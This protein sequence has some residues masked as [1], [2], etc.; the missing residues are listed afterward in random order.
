MSLMKRMNNFLI[1]TT[2]LFLFSE[3]LS[4]QFEHFTVNS[5]NYIFFQLEGL[6]ESINKGSQ[7]IAFGYNTT[8]DTLVIAILQDKEALV[9][10]Y[11]LNDYI[12]NATKMNDPEWRNDT[13]FVSSE[14][15]Y[16]ATTWNLQFVWNSKVES[17][18]AT[19]PEVYDPSTIALGKA[20]SAMAAGNIRLALDWY[21]SVFYPQNYMNEAEVG[22]DIT[23]KCHELALVFFKANQ[24]DSAILYMEMAFSY[25][26]NMYY[27]DF[28]SNAD[29][30]LQIEESPYQIIWT[31]DQIKLWLGDY[32]L[33]LYKAKKYKE[34]IE[35]N[36][37][38][39]S[40][41]PEMAGPYLQ[42]G[43]S[44]YDSGKKTEA[45]KA[46]TKYSSLKKAQKKEKDIPKRVKERSK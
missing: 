18:F 10:G 22:R 44:Y 42:L 7:T 5:E 1:V 41:F 34:S 4:A 17:F 37:Y 33:F 45:K 16:R 15:P 13:V 23:I 27:T 14:M 31:E 28:K 46:Y 2:F 21:Q 38:L 43:D 36:T 29:M 19:E 24:F 40:I 20:D 8:E 11:M 6:G 39:T 25:Y 26:P 9:I 30:K 12:F 3:K 32:G 35:H